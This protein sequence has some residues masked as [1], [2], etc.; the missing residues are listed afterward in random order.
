MSNI[1]L[2]S[3]IGLQ[4]PHLIVPGHLSL[5]SRTNLFLHLTQSSRHNQGMSREKF[6]NEN[7]VQ[8]SS[9]QTTCT[10]CK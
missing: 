8:S 4:R 1:G 10:V 6:K 5:F 2:R 3:G 7:E 9:L